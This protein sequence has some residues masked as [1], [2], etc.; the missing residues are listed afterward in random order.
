MSALGSLVVSLALNYAEYTKGLDKSSQE[1]LK[2]AQ[3]QQQALDKA[4]RATDDFFDKTAKKVVGAVAAYVS[5]TA[6]VNALKGSINELAEADD[7]AQI[8]GSSVENLSKMQKVAR[9]FGGDMSA[10][11]PLLV[12]LAKGMATV[13]SETNKTNKALR[14]LG[15]S[16]KDAAGNLRDPSDVMIEV[17]KR[18]QL[19][20]DSAAKTALMNDA[21]GK[22]AAD[23]LPFFNDLAE[24]VDKFT[25]ATAESAA[26]AAALQDQMGGLKTK[27]HE[28]FEKVAI[29]AMPA[30]SDFAGALDD[31][32]ENSG[33]MASDKSVANWADSIALGLARVIDVARVVPGVFSAIGSSF[34]VVGADIM[35]WAKMVDI[36]A[37][38][39]NPVALASEIAHGRNP[40]AEGAAAAR[41]RD[42]VLAAAN[43]NYSDLWNNPANL[44]EQGVLDRIAARGS[45]PASPYVSPTSGR[46]DLQ[47][48]SGNAPKDKAGNINNSYVADVFGAAIGDLNREGVFADQAERVHEVVQQHI[49]DYKEAQAALDAYNDSWNK[50]LGGLEQSLETLTQENELYGLNAT[51]I[52]AV[53]L[54]RAEENLAIAQRNGVSEEYLSRMARE[55]EL[56]KQILNKTGA[57]EQKR[58][59]TS[60]FDSIESTAH[61]TFVSIFNS[62]KSAFDRLRDTL[63]NGLLDLL[64]QMTIKKWIISVSAAVTGTSAAGAV[65][66]EVAGASGGGLGGL[67]SSGGSIFN[68]ISQG[69][70]GI[71]SGIESLGA[72]IANGSGGIMDAIGGFIGT[73]SG[74]IADALPYA[75]SV[76]SLLSG[77]VKGAALS[78][79]GTAVGSYFGGPIGGAIGSAVGSFVSGLFGDDHEN[80]RAAIRTRLFED[81]TTQEVMRYSK[82][83]GGLQPARDMN[84][85]LVAAFQ[86]TMDVLGVEL[87]RSIVFGGAYNTDKGSYFVYSDSDK[88]G[89][90][91]ANSGRVKTK[92]LGNAAAFIQ[93]EALLGE[94]LLPAWINRVV[95]AMDRS[96]KTGEQDLAFII[97]IKQMH[98]AL[99]TL[100]PE[101]TK[102]Q[103]SFEKFVTQKNIGA[104]T[105]ILAS[106]QTYFDLFY[107]ESEKYDLAVSQLERAYGAL[108]LAI[109]ASRDAYRALVDGMDTSTE[110][111]LGM[112][113][114][115]LALAPSMDAYYKSLEQQKEVIDRLTL[116][117]DRYRTKVD[118]TRAQRYSDSGI[119]VGS[120]PSY[121]V[122]TS[123]V[124]QD[125]PAIIHQ[126]ERIFTAPENSELMQRLRDP[127][128]GSAA[129]I[130]EVRQLRAELKAANVALVQASQKTART[131]D[132]FD[133]DGLPE[134]RTL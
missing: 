129:L 11:N 108:D 134:T 89:D 117:T 43:K 28:L 132:K 61:D 87:A 34:R 115:L 1:A 113:G 52:A 85:Q 121:D 110:A 25:G 35:Y 98:D 109:P 88:P 127:Q 125:G 14:S 53:N 20:N 16:S 23:Q 6:A 74:A 62:G 51:Q 10:I 44:V 29:D 86:N 123:Y 124:P 39:A 63:K 107:S 47:Y 84:A 55:V 101:F 130:A 75:N 93:I 45:Q 105:G 76:I 38:I 40:L 8:T 120:L 70:A 66:G 112:Y 3:R 68:A 2:F 32:W 56:R 67:L 60:I 65:A 90:A 92:D 19:Y 103:L 9:Q 82:D 72:T 102:L 116:S 13:D 71:I 37:R 33:K 31:A 80:P 30:M 83:G 59:W 69:N 128:A 27:V 64:Y 79:I 114:A 26:R 122:G 78:A 100:P 96:V 131:L 126:G 94:K 50:H 18:L 7:L 41:E 99:A 73:N 54:Q 95:E 12:K 104:F 133:N 17:A 106:A 22:S 49:A 58:A 36:A 42:A 81:G 111:G 24:N 48:E 91:L 4:G 57:L 46:L 5:V 118:F 77:D 97:G 15:V 21:M 119:N